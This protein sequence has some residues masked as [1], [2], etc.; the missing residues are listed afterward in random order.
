MTGGALDDRG[1]ISYMGNFYQ[2]GFDFVAKRGFFRFCALKGLRISAQ[3][4][5]A[6]ATLGRE[7]TKI[8][9]QRG[10]VKGAWENNDATLSGLV[11]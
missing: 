8:Q 4:C 9:P 1:E 3:G 11:A 7:G 6:A 10:C 2:L 5:C